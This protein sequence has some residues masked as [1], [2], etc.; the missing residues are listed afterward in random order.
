LRDGYRAL[1]RHRPG[2]GCPVSGARH[3]WG[4][5]RMQTRPGI[6][7]SHCVRRLTSARR[8]F[9]PSRRPSHTPR[10]SCPEH[11]TGSVDIARRP[12][13]P[14]HLICEGSPAMTS[15]PAPGVPEDPRQVVLDALSGALQR[16]GYLTTEW[17]TTV[18]AGLLS[19]VL[20]LVGLAGPAAAQITGILAPVLVAGLYAVVR[21]MHKS[22]LAEVLSAA[23]PHLRQHRR[24]PSQRRHRPADRPH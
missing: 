9:L 3:L 13:H 22:A 2:H 18:A 20:A 12:A 17:W 19:A 6:M 16:R 11:A 23:L 15:D 14:P 24:R 10:L 7:A 5:A 1:C 21:T 4:S 8:S